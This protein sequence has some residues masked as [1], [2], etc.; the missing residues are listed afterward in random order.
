VSNPVYTDE[1]YGVHALSSGSFSVPSDVRWVVTSIFV[2]Y[3]G[4]AISSSFQLVNPDTLVTRFFDAAGPDVIGQFRIFSGF[5]LVL[6]EGQTFD[7][8]GLN[9]PDV[10]INGY[11]LTL[12]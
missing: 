8:S 4:G 5:R 10:S 11:V 7:T 1:L 2:F 9:S 12:P 3:P 6:L